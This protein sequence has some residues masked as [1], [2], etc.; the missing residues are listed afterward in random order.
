[1]IGLV[2]N[3]NLV[4]NSM[5]KLPLLLKHSEP[6]IEPVVVDSAHYGTKNKRVLCRY[7]QQKA[8]STKLV[9]TISN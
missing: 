1:M 2:D 7:K 9:Q 5:A 6:N 3:G 4:K 8:M